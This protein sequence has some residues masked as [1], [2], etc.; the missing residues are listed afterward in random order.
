MHP[1][2]DECSDSLYAGNGRDPRE[3]LYG[4]LL[5]LSRTPKLGPFSATA[6]ITVT[7]E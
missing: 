1:L 5:W 7:F 3:H 2:G 6:K 4:G